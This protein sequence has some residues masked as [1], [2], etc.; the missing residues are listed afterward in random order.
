MPADIYF[1]ID[2]GVVLAAY[3]MTAS[4]NNNVKGFLDSLTLMPNIEVQ[5][6]ALCI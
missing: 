5:L 4:P 6:L 3:V 1:E 2:L